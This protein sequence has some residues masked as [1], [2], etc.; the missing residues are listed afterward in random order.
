MLLIPIALPL[1]VIEVFTPV[2]MF[3]KSA[4]GEHLLSVPFF[5]IMPGRVIEH[6]AIDQYSPSHTHTH[7]KQDTQ[8][9]T[10]WMPHLPT[11][12][13]A[14]MHV[15]INKH[16]QI[17]AQAHLHKGLCLFA[18]FPGY[19]MITIPL[20]T[21]FLPCTNPL[22]AIGAMGMMK[23]C[24]QGPWIILFHKLNMQ[25]HKHIMANLQFRI[26]V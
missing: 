21:V 19:E 25:R 5:L 8:A 18:H 3:Y 20:T 10:M 22:Y 23:H 2:H 4:V 16:A 11:A 6:I 14:G 13:H 24:Y 1:G 9:Q 15:N 7:T 26:D 17:N 12:M